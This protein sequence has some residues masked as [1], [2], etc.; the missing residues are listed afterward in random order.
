M[1]RKF[2][3]TLICLFCFSVSCFASEQEIINSFTNFTNNIS[4]EIRENY[5]EV[6]VVYVP[7]DRDTDYGD[8]WVKRQRTNLSSSFDIQ[9]TTSLI[10]PYMGILILSNDYTLYHS[11]DNLKG[12]YQTASEAEKADIPVTSKGDGLY[13]FT[14]MY[15][16][17]EWVLK[18]V[19]YR[20]TKYDEYY[21]DIEVKSP[22]ETMKL[23]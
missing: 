22:F 3:L 4:N 21:R 20:N 7:Y 8:F 14:Y 19:Q 17:G 9:Q 15:Q 18:R 12:N 13:K 6:K 2:I 16:S 11:T 10:S 5:K 1:M 23:I